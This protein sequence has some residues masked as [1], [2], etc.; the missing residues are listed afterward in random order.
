MR[1]VAPRRAR[2][3]CTANH[4]AQLGLSASSHMIDCG[5]HRL[6]IRQIQSTDGASGPVALLLH[7]A[8]S[9]GEFF[10]SRKGR[11]LGPYL[12][13]AGFNVF[14]PD[15][16]GRGGS[17][18]SIADEAAASP[19]SPPRHGQWEAIRE[20]LPTIARAVAELSGR[21]GQAWAA[22]SWG[23]VLMQAALASDPELARRHCE[24][25]ACFGVKKHISAPRSW[26]ERYDY[27]MDI[28]LGW[29]RLAPLLARRYGYLPARRLGIGGDDEPS[30]FLRASAAWVRVP[31]D[32]WIDERDGFDYAAAY[33]ALG[34]DRPP[35]WHLAGAAD[36]VRG[37]PRDVASWAAATGHDRPVD[38]LT[39]LS[40]AAGNLEDYDHNSLLLSKLA[41]D[42]THFAGV[43][44]WM[45]KHASKE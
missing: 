44:E 45:R 25:L 4:Y 14:V 16:R 40:R 35:V 18:P 5:K 3:L 34:D 37:N 17:T 23:G 9:N 36:T 41:P 1:A 28:E 32:E 43:A 21:E 31:N 2:A 13:Q 11:G 29:H 12:A 38:R 27:V 19:A 6:H 10:Y 22:H 42:D 24:S 15:L 33:R 20:D 39:V 8:M 26:R 7:G 30:E